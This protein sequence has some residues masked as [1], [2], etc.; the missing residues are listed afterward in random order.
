VIVKIV[1]E[2]VNMRRTKMNEKEILQKIKTWLQDNVDNE[3][4]KDLIQ[5][6]KN[7]LKFIKMWENMEY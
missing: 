4:Q 2:N 1:A 7:L 3:V 6:N 5:D